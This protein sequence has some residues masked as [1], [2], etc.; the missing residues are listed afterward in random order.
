MNCFDLL[1][2]PTNWHRINKNDERRSEKK[3]QKSIGNET[4]VTLMVLLSYLKSIYFANFSL[5][6]SA[7][8]VFLFFFFSFHIEDRIK[9]LFAFISVNEINRISVNR[10]VLTSEFY[11]TIENMCALTHTLIPSFDGSYFFFH[12][13]LLFS[14]SI[15]LRLTRLFVD[16]SC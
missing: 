14:F 5:F 7:V 10:N 6:L 15:L 3:K 9:K 11:Y 4:M 2:P 8:V 16:L 1:T 13:F 12:F